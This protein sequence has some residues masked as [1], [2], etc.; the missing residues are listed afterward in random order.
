MNLSVKSVK[1][2]LNLKPF[3]FLRNWRKGLQV[4]YDS[5]KDKWAS[6]LHEKFYSKSIISLNLRGYNE[7]KALG[8]RGAKSFAEALPHSQ[9]M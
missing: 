7:K 8:S 5:K 3:F 1:A 6:I 2:F 4:N 9:I